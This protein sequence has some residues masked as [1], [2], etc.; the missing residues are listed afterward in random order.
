MTAP[1]TSGLTHRWRFFSAIWVLLSIVAAMW[2]LGT[3]LTTGP[4]EPSHFVKAAAVVHG[5]L[6]GRP[7]AEGMVVQVPAYVAYTPAQTCTAY[8]PDQTA[9]CGPAT[10]EPTGLIM[11]G[12]T[13]AGSYNPLYYALVGWPTLL[14][15]DQTGLYAMRIVSGVIASAFLALGFMML[16]SWRRRV[17]PPLGALVAVTPMVLYMNGVVNPSSLEIAGTFAAFIALLGIVVDP[18]PGL[19]TERMIILTLGAAVACSTRSISPLWIALL[20]LIPLLLL[21]RQAIVALLRHRA[22]W[23]G[24]SIVALVAASGV[25]WTVLSSS[26]TLAS[27]ENAGTTVYDNVGA[28]PVFGFIKMIMLTVNLG[29]QMVGILGWFDT[30]L[31]LPVYFTWSAL[32]GSLGITAAVIL[33]GRRAVMSLALFALLILGPAVV[34]AIYITGGGFIWQGRYTLPLFVCAVV[35]I[36]TV[37]SLTWTSLDHRLVVRLGIIV[38]TLWVAAQILSYLQAIRRYSVGASGSYQAIFTAPAWSPPLGAATLIAIALAALA[39]TVF[40]V[41]RKTAEPAST[42]AFSPVEL[43]VPPDRHRP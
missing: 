16:R 8:N 6:A 32:I 38:G 23:V 31:P 33:R 3:P 1:R 41:V 25:A 36:A 11:E 18:R 43:P 2:S 21:S 28:S 22:V 30:L 19:V 29:Q 12:T 7:S 40:L 20:L 10:P 15:S 17:L 34:Q 37:V 35:G 27:P 26:L 5:Q 24:V 39:L 14:F 42:A 9:N 13:T 4:D